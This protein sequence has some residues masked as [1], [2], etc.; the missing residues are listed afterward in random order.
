MNIGASRG[1]VGLDKRSQ[2]TG[3]AR[4]DDLQPQ[5]TQFAPLSLDG[6]GYD[7]LVLSPAAALAAAFTTQV[8]LIHLHMSRSFS[9]P[10]RIVQLRSFCNQRHAVL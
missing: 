7:A 10:F 5:P 6:H 1:N 4:V 9:R 8:K 2:V 3:R